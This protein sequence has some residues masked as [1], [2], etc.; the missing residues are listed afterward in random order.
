M[1]SVDTAYGDKEENSWSAITSWGVWH[2]RDEAPRAMLTSAWRGRPKLRTDP[3]TRELGL[4]ER[5]HKMATEQNADTILIEKKTR[6]VD[7]YQE[8]EMQVQEWPYRLEYWD[9]TGRGDKV[10]RLHSLTSLFTNDLIWAPNTK[11]AEVTIAEVCAQP[12][13]KFSDL[14]DTC[15]ASLLYLRHNGLLTLPDEH[16]REQIRTRGQVSVGAGR[17][18]TVAE[19]YEGA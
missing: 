14:T 7:L 2:G 5:A 18:N 8:L 9:P 16:R 12:R 1:L 11:W 3:L 6:G 17:R 4:I 15:T 19:L 13:A 10:H